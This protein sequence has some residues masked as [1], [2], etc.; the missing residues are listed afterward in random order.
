MHERLDKLEKAQ[1]Q[2][3]DQNQKT[4]PPI[5]LGEKVGEYVYGSIEQHEEKDERLIE[6][7]GEED[8]LRRSARSTGAVSQSSQQ[9]GTSSNLEEMKWEAEPPLEALQ[10]VVFPY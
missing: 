10:Y 4:N 1:D 6:W 8:N 9:Q 3:L 5:I 2:G 7:D